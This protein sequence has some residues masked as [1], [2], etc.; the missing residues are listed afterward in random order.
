MNLKYLQ[1]L[2]VKTKEIKEG[3]ER[4][5]NT[6]GHQFVPVSPSGPTLCVACDKSVS[7]KELLQCSSK[8][9][10]V[11]AVVLC[12][13]LLNCLGVF[14]ACFSMFYLVKNMQSVFSLF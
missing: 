12:L 1:F 3:K 8:C 13:W 7:G 2:Q 5:G 14:C 11:S 9:C 4:S 6:N 10:T